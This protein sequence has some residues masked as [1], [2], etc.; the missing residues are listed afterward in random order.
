MKKV[1][2]FTTD[3][4]QISEFLRA[5]AD[6]V[7]N[8][9]IL[10]GHARKK[11]VFCY[12]FPNVSA[13]VLRPEL[14]VEQLLVPQPGETGQELQDKGGRTTYKIK[15]SHK[16]KNKNVYNFTLLYNFLGAVREKYPY[17]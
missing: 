17:I 15:T 14:D 9:H 1:A 10:K 5:F 6:R 16:N 2:D 7:S 4:S 8:P 11:Y 13:A 3:F 12:P